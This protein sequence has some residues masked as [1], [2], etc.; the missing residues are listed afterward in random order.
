MFYCVLTVHGHWASGAGLQRES[1]I[2]DDVQLLPL[3]R[4]Y[5]V[6]ERFVALEE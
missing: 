5:R 1:G 2:S 6:E 3:R 4:A